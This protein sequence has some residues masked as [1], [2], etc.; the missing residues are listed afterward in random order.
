M[1]S[2]LDSFGGRRVVGLGGEHSAADHVEGEGEAGSDEPGV[3]R[4]FGGGEEHDQDTDEGGDRGHDDGDGVVTLFVVVLTARV[5]C[6]DGGDHAAHPPG[7]LLRVH[8]GEIEGRGDEVRDDVDPDGRDHERQ[9]TE[10]DDVD[11]V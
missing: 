3:G 9:G 5:E 4:C 1:S 6:V 2:G 8:V 7:D 10:D 11:V